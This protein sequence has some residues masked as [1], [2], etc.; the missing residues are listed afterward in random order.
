MR[1]VYRGKDGRFI[2]ESSAKRRKP[3]NV[4]TELRDT[5]DKSIGSSRGYYTS[6]KKLSRAVLPKL[7]LKTKKR[8]RVEPIKVRRKA[9]T[10]YEEYAPEPE[11]YEE[12]D[13]G[14]LSELEDEWRDDFADDF[15]DDLDY[16][17]DL[18]E[19]LTDEDEWYED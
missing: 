19:L 11:T 10:A 2:S 18:E 15:G 7:K 3:Q 17:D 8:P 14:E 13:E 5:R 4:I 1:I 6:F 12:L 9:G 16:M